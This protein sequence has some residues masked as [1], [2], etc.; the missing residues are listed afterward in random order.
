MIVTVPRALG[1]LVCASFMSCVT[2][3]A[4][5]GA[6]AAPGSVAGPVPPSG[7]FGVDVAAGPAFEVATA[8]ERQSQRAVLGVPALTIRL[9]S[10]LDYAVEG[11][12][13]RHVTPVSG[14][15]FGIVPVA[16]RVHTRGRTQTHLSLGSGIGWSDLAGLHGVE[17]RQNFVTHL[18]AGIS[19]VR[20]NGSGVSV[21]ARFFHM[22]N[23][24]AAPPNLGMEVFTVLVGYRLPR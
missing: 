9:F 12:L 6:A 23:L 24:H 17:Q 16:F 3:G 21:E 19:R 14:N 1:L 13:S 8:G 5:A 7:R 10:W 2:L 18:G 15:V 20:P 22:S 11:H 4:Q